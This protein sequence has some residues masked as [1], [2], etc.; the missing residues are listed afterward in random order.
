M[1]LSDRVFRVVRAGYSEEQNRAI[2][3]LEEVQ[4]HG[5][6]VVP[7]RRL[8]F[9]PMLDETQQ[10]QP[11]WQVQQELNRMFTFADEAEAR[12]VYNLSME[13][14]F[15]REVERVLSG[16]SAAGVHCKERAVAV[17]IRAGGHYHI[18][19][20]IASRQSHSGGRSR[21]NGCQLGAGDAQRLYKR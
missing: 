21:I 8:R 20:D 1:H 7:V 5:D 2:V 15:R 12:R 11:M 18:H 14:A 9:E 10:V 6:R 19:D 16:R 13:D 4:F 3:E 17:R